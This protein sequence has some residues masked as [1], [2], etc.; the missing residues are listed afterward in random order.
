MKDMVWL[1]TDGKEYEV[2][3]II[4]NRTGRLLRKMPFGFVAT[5][6]VLSGS[7]STNDVVPLNDPRIAGLAALIDERVNRDPQ[8]LESLRKVFFTPK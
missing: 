8:F 2:V 6:M 5:N 3:A 4:D 1:G 7:M